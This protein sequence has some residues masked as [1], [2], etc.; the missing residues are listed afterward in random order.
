MHLTPR[1]PPPHRR[2]GEPARRRCCGH[3]RAPRDRAADGDSPD[4]LPSTSDDRRVPACDK[5]WRRG[6][7]GTQE[8]VGRLR[9]AGRRRWGGQF[10]PADDP[11]SPPMPRQ[12]R[13]LADR[14]ATWIAAALTAAAD[15]PHHRSHRA[16][17]VA[18]SMAVETA[19]APVLA[20]L[21][22]SWPPQAIGTSTPPVQAMPA[23]R[24][25]VSGTAASA[26][27]D[28]TRQAPDP[29]TGYVR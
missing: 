12:D 16:V 29:G 15:G 10:Y 22:P 27:G 14:W 9:D 6:F 1:R 21:P 8:P 3:A 24:L 17:T 20:T 18:H 25:Q 2:P 23:A 4:R 7:S 13:G 26:P 28:L 5:A 19:P 11:A